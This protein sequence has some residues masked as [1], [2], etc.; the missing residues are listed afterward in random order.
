MFIQGGCCKARRSTIRKNTSNG[1]WDCHRGESFR[2]HRRKCSTNAALKWS[3][4][5]RQ[6]AVSIKYL[7][8]IYS[9]FS[10]IIANFQMLKTCFVSA[11]PSVQLRQRMEVPPPSEQDITLLMGLGFDR[12]TVVRVLRSSGN[13]T[14][15]AANRLLG[16]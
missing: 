8:L 1:V 13:D 10:A 2:K 5:Y 6:A 14:E 4:L 9:S 16:H 3:P 7:V 11:L 12:D 15:A